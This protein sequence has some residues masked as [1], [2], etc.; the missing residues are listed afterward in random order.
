MISPGTVKHY[1]LLHKLGLFET[2][3]FIFSYRRFVERI[4]G[5]HF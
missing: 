4:S 5:P 3:N 1:S 2:V